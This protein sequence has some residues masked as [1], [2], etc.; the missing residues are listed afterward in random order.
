MRALFSLS[1]KERRFFTIRFDINI[2]LI[3]ILRFF[4]LI[5]HI[6]VELVQALLILRMHFIRTRQIAGFQIGTKIG[7]IAFLIVFNFWGQKQTVFRIKTINI[8][9]KNT[10]GSLGI[11]THI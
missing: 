2:R 10:L 4:Q 7:T 8:E 11:Q 6:G 1:F 3:Q 5:Q 9:I